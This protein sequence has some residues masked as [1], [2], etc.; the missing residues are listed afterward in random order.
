MNKKKF[1]FVTMLTAALSSLLINQALAVQIRVFAPS[2]YAGVPP[3]YPTAF[4]YGLA[5]ASLGSSATID[6][7]S[8]STMLTAMPPWPPAGYGCACSA[9]T[10]GW[11]RFNGSTQQGSVHADTWLI[12]G[13][14]ATGAGVRVK[15]WVWEWPTRQCWTK[16]WGD[17]LPTP[18]HTTRNAVVDLGVSTIDRSVPGGFPF[19]W[20][21]GRYYKTDIVIAAGSLPSTMAFVDLGKYDDCLLYTSDAADE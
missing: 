16:V 10:T 13:I 3:S 19:M 9:F 8:G 14:N 5:W 18:P 15:L 17:G 1:V 21:N 7:L 11:Y 6:P 2:N 20:T 12:Y 4:S